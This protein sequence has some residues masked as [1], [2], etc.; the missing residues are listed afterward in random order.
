VNRP[1]APA[2]TAAA[3]RGGASVRVGVL[4]L[5]GA[6]REHAA[7]LERS[8]ALVRRCVA[9]SISTGSTGS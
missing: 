3:V 9:P 6:F 4:A 7:A 2:A 5:Q 1:E 8:G